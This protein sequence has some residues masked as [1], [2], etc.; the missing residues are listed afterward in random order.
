M[1]FASSLREGAWTAVVYGNRI[2][3]FPVGILVTA[4]L[5]PLFPLFSRLVAEKDFDGIRNYFNKG[6][7]VLFFVAIPM[8][9]C[10]L[11]FAMFFTITFVYES[12][13]F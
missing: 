4:F 13:P 3:Q 10:I 12:L 9:I 8:T 6:V 2:F 5:V 7:G 11:A 1:F